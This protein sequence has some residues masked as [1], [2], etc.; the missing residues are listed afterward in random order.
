M[1]AFE[2]LRRPSTVE[3]KHI[4]K[5]ESVHTDGLRTQVHAVDGLQL[6]RNQALL[7]FRDR[8]RRVKAFDGLHTPSTAGEGLHT[9][10]EY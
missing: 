8:R 2:G 6:S 3:I 5:A 10:H 7:D 9:S 4:E 1:K